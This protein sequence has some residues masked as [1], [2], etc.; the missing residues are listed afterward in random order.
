MQNMND[1][2]A[3]TDLLLAAKTGVRNYAYAITEAASPDVRQVLSEQLQQAVTFHEQVTNYM[4]KNGYYHPYNL[5][6]QIQY[7]QQAAQQSIQQQPP[8]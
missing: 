8:Q 6:E 5:N 1:Q 4:I 7:D 3:A 2:A